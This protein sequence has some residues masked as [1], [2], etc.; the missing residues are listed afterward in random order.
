MD[1]NMLEQLQTLLDKKA[2]EDQILHYAHL[3]DGKQFEDFY[4]VMVPGAWI[5]YTASGGIKGSVEDMKQYLSKSMAMFRS[6]HLM[7]NI[8]TT[9]AP[10]RKT[11]KSTH[12]LF[13]P[14]T[15]TLKG[16]DH[17]FFCGLWYDCDWVRCEDGVWRIEK[18]IQLEGYTHNAPFPLKSK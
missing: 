4:D 6:Q 1:E 9:I 13:N 14:M 12:I 16:Q 5:D 18:M 15:M 17:T 8:E 2:I 11:A 7:T 10:D 3:V